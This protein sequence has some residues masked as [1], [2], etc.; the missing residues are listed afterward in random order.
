MKKGDIIILSNGKKAKIVN[1]DINKYK[2]ILIVEMENQDIRVVDRESLSLV[3]AAKQV[4]IAV[5]LTVLSK[6]KMNK[7]LQFCV[8]MVQW[9]S[10]F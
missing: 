2:N 3:R 10:E 8:K 7:S 6:L 1:A 9:M 5:L 4:L